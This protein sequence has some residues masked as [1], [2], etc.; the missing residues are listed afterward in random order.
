MLRLAGLVALARISGRIGLVIGGLDR[1]FRLGGAIGGQGIGRPVDARCLTAGGRCGRDRRRFLR[2]IVARR[3]APSIACQGILVRRVGL[4][5]ATRLML[6]GNGEHGPLGLGGGGMH[7]VTLHELGHLGLDVG[8][9][10]G[11]QLLRLACRGAAIPLLQLHPQQLEPQVVAARLADQARLEQLACLVVATVGDEDIGLV[12]GLGLWHGGAYRCPRR[13]VAPGGRRLLD[14]PVAG[15]GHHHA[16]GRGVHRTGL[17]E[18][19]RRRLLLATPPAHQGPERQQGRQAGTAQHQGAIDGVLIEPSPPGCRRCLRRLTA[20]GHHAPRPGGI[21]AAAARGEA[22]QLLTHGLHLLAQI[23]ERRL[24]CVPLAAHRLQ[25]LLALLPARL[26]TQQA[27]V[28]GELAAALD[29]RQHLGVDDTPLPLFRR[30]AR[31]SGRVARLLHRGGRTCRL[32]RLSRLTVGCVLSG[33]TSLGGHLG[34]AQQRQPLTALAG[35]LAAVARRGRCRVGRRFFRTSRRRLGSGTGHGRSRLGAAEGHPGR[36]A[37]AAIGP[38]LVHRLDELAG[39]GGGARRD[40][41]T[42]RDHQGEAGAHG[43]DVA[44]GKDLRVGLDQGNHHLVHADAAVR[45]Q[46]AR[47]GPQGVAGTHPGGVA[48]AGGGRGARHGAR[49][50]VRYAG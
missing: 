17:V 2:C 6:V 19:R 33:E 22:R 8:I 3:H 1:G 37:A 15:T 34:V 50:G 4:I 26:E 43:V 36:D 24:E 38:G 14:G 20:R 41:L 7:R 42:G 48:R 11:A 27:L 12:D 46:P 21:D 35:G 9:P 32:S 44:G 16:A 49:R 45:A 39:P 30:R 25:G 5:E 10:A 29:H 18:D 31:E 28:L 40:G 23:A 13:L 47:H